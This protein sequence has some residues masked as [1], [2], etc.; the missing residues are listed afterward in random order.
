M[1]N[2][3]SLEEIERMKDIVPF[4]TN[5]E[6]KGYMLD[7][8]ESMMKIIN[9][10]ING[11]N[12]YSYISLE[13]KFRI[14]KN[15]LKGEGRGNHAF[16]KDTA[17]KIY[18]YIINENIDRQLQLEAIIKENYIKRNDD[19]FKIDNKFEFKCKE[20]VT[21]LAKSIK[22][23]FDEHP[24][25]AST[26]QAKTLN[27]V[28][29]HFSKVFSSDDS[30]DILK[31]HKELIKAIESV[32][33]FYIFE[34]ENDVDISEISFDM[35]DSKRFNSTHKNG[36]GYKSID[37]IKQFFKDKKTFDTHKEVDN[38][39]YDFDKFIANFCK[40]YNYNI[41]YLFYNK[42][43]RYVTIKAYESIIEKYFKNKNCEEDENNN[44]E[45]EVEMMQNQP[46]LY[47]VNDHDI[48]SELNTSNS[49]LK[50][51]IIYFTSS[52]SEKYNPETQNAKFVIKLLEKAFLRG[53]DNKTLLTFANELDFIDNLEEY[54]DI[55]LQH[56][57]KVLSNLEND[58]QAIKELE[59]L[60]AIQEKN[61]E[62]FSL[63]SYPE[64]LNLL[65]A[66]YKR[67]AFSIALDKDDETLKNTFI[68]Q[69]SKASDL[70][71]KALL[72]EVKDKYYPAINISYL[73]VIIGNVQKRDYEETEDIL[74]ELWKNI[75]IDIKNYWSWI[76]SVEQNILFQNYEKAK[77]RIQNYREEIDQ[78][79]ELF[80]INSTAR[81]LAFYS[82]FCDQEDTEQ[83]QEI[84][85]LLYKIVS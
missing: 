67:T 73:E 3:L 60:I 77:E 11:I 65:A 83:I 62:K 7:T 13:Q 71:K 23:Y 9:Q 4:I 50:E 85:A 35:I 61:P 25:L 78:D 6:A 43:S 38:H 79:I 20:D 37:S 57:A 26:K 21:A 33:E 18:K 56:K 39:Y 32:F 68:N 10:K 8:I 63:S 42:Q 36:I 15:C 30:E 34:D 82:T 2:A 29:T 74:D 72:H 75:N 24:S 5:H 28:I 45:N 46:N 64:T 1:G 52:V 81:Q 16:A 17:K 51:M 53:V 55:I 14:I 41:D 31:S 59:K 27:K 66:S 22:R 19:Q 76:T 47:Y 84:I 80:H 58:V 12:E 69:L 48:K 44:E 70:Y 40:V 54:Q 49:D